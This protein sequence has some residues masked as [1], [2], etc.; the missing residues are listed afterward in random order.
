MGNTAVSTDASKQP[1]GWVRCCAR[2]A[3][4][5]P[6][7][8]IVHEALT[9][10]DAVKAAATNDE[11]SLVYL[12]N[13]GKFCIHNLNLLEG[14]SRRANIS[15]YYDLCK[16]STGLQAT[17][18]AFGLWAK[19]KKHNSHAKTI[20]T[21]PLRSADKVGSGD[22]CRIFFFDDN[23]EW[24]GTENSTGICNLRNAETGEFVD[25]TEGTNGF[26]SARTNR[27]T[28]IYYS[29]Q[30]NVVLCKANILDAMENKDYFSAIIQKYSEVDEKIIVYMD[31]NS[32]IVCNDTVQGKDLA[33]SLMGTMFEFVDCT[34]KEPYE[35]AFKE[36]KT[37]KVE[38][39]QTLKQL[40]KS[41]T[42][43]NHEH[44]QRFW[45][46]DNCRDFI[47][48]VVK[49]T[50]MKWQGQ[51]KL[52]VE[53]FFNEFHDYCEKITAAVDEDGITA[54][55]FVCFDEL[56]SDHMVVLNSFGTD[57]RK[58]IL[59]TVVDELVVMQIA[60]NYETW[61]GRDLKKYG[62]QFDDGRASR[63]SCIVPPPPKK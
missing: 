38:K 12:G 60:V 50:E 44:Y 31:V 36:Y 10:H 3:A 63:G 25:F 2:T 42:D 21:V 11:V 1:D 37:I 56:K 30:Y 55:W 4:P 33:Q 13:G 45:L 18:S 57:C 54:S 40:V 52:D 39:K 20:P 53:D 17:T 24:E 8:I 15:W 29:D 49:F 47:N 43:G 35:L 7:T 6:E 27:H 59:A 61:G 23:L 14:D 62:T 46:E 5:D 9:E 16:R 34:C 26:S 32:T 19:S 51:K 28:V 22:R 48:E 41:I 58:V